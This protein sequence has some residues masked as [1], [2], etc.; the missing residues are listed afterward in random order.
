MVR[1]H[2][3]ETLSAPGGKLPVVGTQRNVINPEVRCMVSCTDLASRRSARGRSPFWALPALAL[4]T[5]ALL[6]A[7]AAAQMAT[8]NIVG[9]VKDSSGA[10]IP[11]VTVTGKMV[12][13]QATRATRT[14]A[15]GFYNL[16]SLPPGK[17]EL[18]FEVKGFQKQAQTGLELSVGQ[19]LR[20]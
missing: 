7:P 10:A 12:E 17:Y 2:C 11:D 14:N 3:R 16:L 13:Q 6:V 8:G 9:Y 1:E 20:V 5:V 19:Y 4:L 15:E 18:T